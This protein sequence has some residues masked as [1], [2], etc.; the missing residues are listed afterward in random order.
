MWKNK[1]GFKIIA[2]A[3]ALCLSL[4]SMAA[5]AA[6]PIGSAVVAEN[7][8]TEI[9][10][11]NAKTDYGTLVYVFDTKIDTSADLADEKF[12]NEHL[13]YA[14]Q[15][16]D[17]KVELTLPSPGVYGVVAGAS[18][19]PKELTED[20]IYNFAYYTKETENALLGEISNALADE[21]GG[22]KLEETL[23]FY[24]G[25][26]YVSDL[27]VVWTDVFDL[28]KSAPPQS[29]NDVSKLLDA[30][31]GIKFLETTEKIE[32]IGE[33]IEK[34]VDYITL[35][36]DDETNEK[37]KQDFLKAKDEVALRFLDLKKTD[38]KTENLSDVK[39][40]FRI[41]AALASVNTAERDNI[42]ETIRFYNDLFGVNFDGDYKSV[43]EY[44]LRKLLTGMQCKTPADVRKYV[45]EAIGK[46]K[47]GDDSNH[48]SVP[49]PSS[50]GG[51]GGGGGG[52]TTAAGS[53][54]SDAIDNLVGDSEKF[55][56][57]TDFSWAKEAAEVL[58]LKGIMVGDGNGLFRPQDKV[59]REEFAKI[60]LTL[61][62]GK[63]SV[64]K[65]AFIDVQEDAWY[66]EYISGAVEYQM[67][68]GIDENMF[69]VGQPI[70]REDAA[71]IFNR[72]LDSFDIS[73]EAIKSIVDFD[74]LSEVSD[75]AK[76][77]MDKLARVGII[78]GFED[79]TLRPK[80]TITRAEAAAMAYRIINKREKVKK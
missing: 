80:E 53:V 39:R 16:T 7:G 2:I 75:Y 26:A 11:K 77:A 51:F 1:T 71:V 43:S 72:A 24:N 15:A 19:L 50:G 49:R 52:V 65:T 47:T 17:G 40:V 57:M 48:V 32:G 34:C 66:A 18:G 62:G 76:I 79:N 54:G 8:K 42:I 20:R 64:T 55:S 73:F 78:S 14:A 3:A 13:I 25:K 35:L 69:G 68:N 36:G 22:S 67:I 44:E 5:Y 56:D 74:D 33:N 61:F 60:A 38:E 9:V 58:S 29:A 21:N 45:S 28:F 63:P 41:S 31:E 59:T 23:K 10:L 46:L 12:M 37:I 70:T 4:S 6:E 27:D 30:A